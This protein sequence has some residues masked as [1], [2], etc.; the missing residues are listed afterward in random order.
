MG[1]GLCRPGA[2]VASDFSSRGPC[3]PGRPPSQLSALVC[4]SLQW[5]PSPSSMGCWEKGGQGLCR[6]VQGSWEWNNPACR[7]L[8]LWPSPQGSHPR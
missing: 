5:A 7:P 1:A 6:E 8:T 3:D 4:P 2:R